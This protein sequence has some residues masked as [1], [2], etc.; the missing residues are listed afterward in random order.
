MQRFNAPLFAGGSN[1]NP[2]Q[3]QKLFSPVSHGDYAN[4]LVFA[5]SPQVNPQESVLSAIESLNQQKIRSDAET[6]PEPVPAH[7]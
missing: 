3:I 2:E 6:K 1:I 7:G 4:T 5:P